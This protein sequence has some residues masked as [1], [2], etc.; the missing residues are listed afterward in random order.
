[1]NT[2]RTIL[3]SSSKQMAVPQW[4]KG[5][6]NGAWAL[7]IRLTHQRSSSNP[8]KLFRGN[9]TIHLLGTMHIAEAS[10]VAARHLI[11]HE[12]AKGTLGSVFLELDS[13][14]F[15]RLRDL[16]NQQADES[17]FSHAMSIL[18]RPSQNP[19]ASI[20]ELAFT[21][22][23]RTLHRLGFGSGVEFKAA[24][25]VAERHNI[26][27]V[28]GDQHVQ[29]TLRRLADGFGKDF[30]LP[31]LMS[32]VLSQASKTSRPETDT[33]RKI[34]Q[35]FQ[36][37]AQGDVTRAQERLAKLIDQESVRE[38]MRPMQ[39]YAPNVTNAILHERDVVMAENLI[40]AADNLPPDKN[41]IV[42]IVGLAHMDG[43]CSE[44]QKRNMIKEYES[45]DRT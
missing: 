39:K 33:E 21:T 35:A 43:I 44:W 22:M 23:Y 4:C 40:S 5:A 41:N 2:F 45:S 24:I 30:D 38:I 15:Q 37:I 3:S 32:I 6:R 18:S 27:I 42:A 11:Q 9:S 7:G 14:R 31:R 1:M 28:L 25:E 12:H 19:V 20:V 13:P 26:P 36:S 10:A 16:Q 29:T 17:M 34:R 8:T